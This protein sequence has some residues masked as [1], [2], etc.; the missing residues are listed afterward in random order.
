MISVIACTNEPWAVDRSFLRPGR[1][2]RQIFIGTYVYVYVSTYLYVRRDIC[3][4]FMFS[5]CISILSVSFFNLII[6]FFLHILQFPYLSRIVNL[7]LSSS[8]V[9]YF[10][11]D[12][13]RFLLRF[14]PTS[15]LLFC[16]HLNYFPF[17][18]SVISTYLFSLTVKLFGY[19]TARN[20]LFFLSQFCFFVI[21]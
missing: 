13:S 9:F 11:S 18:F 19:N 15:P 8:Y 7:L 5:C 1:F 10:M 2:S 4:I 6:L 14:R 3:H 20:V 21:I 16:P 17:C 12:T